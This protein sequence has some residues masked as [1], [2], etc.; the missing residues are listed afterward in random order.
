MPQEDL[1]CDANYIPY[2]HL[3]ELAK[4]CSFPGRNQFKMSIYKAMKSLLRC[5]VPVETEEEALQLNGVGLNIAREITKSRSINLC[6]NIFQ[7]RTT[8]ENLN[9]V[10]QISKRSLNKIYSLEAGKGPCSLLV[11]LHN[12]QGK[13]GDKSSLLLISRQLEAKVKCKLIVLIIL[14]DFFVGHQCIES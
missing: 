5:P 1:A 10:K 12:S 4:S 13:K 7:E 11:C 14:D 8:T 6:R 3:E 9:S 2:K